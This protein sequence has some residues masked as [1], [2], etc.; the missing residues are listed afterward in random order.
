MKT[1][2]FVIATMLMI[3]SVSVVYAHG[4]ANHT[5]TINDWHVYPCGHT[6]YAGNTRQVDMWVGDEDEEDADLWSTFHTSSGDH[7]LLP[8]HINEMQLGME[9]APCNRGSLAV[10]Y[11]VFYL[12]ICEY[13]D[14]FGV[15]PNAYCFAQTYFVGQ[16]DLLYCDAHLR[17]W[18]HV[19]DLYNWE[20]DAIHDY[21]GPWEI[22]YD[23][24]ID[25][26]CE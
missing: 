4:N 15:D 13:N 22:D 12:W 17:F 26:C 5:L 23:Y 16:I 11:V 24:C 21:F 19:E 9:Q 7:E 3:T 8:R 2:L 1:R 10:D 14:D 25:H 20:D 18:G 6:E